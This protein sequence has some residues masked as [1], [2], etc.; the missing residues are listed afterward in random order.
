MKKLKTASRD[1]SKEELPAN[2]V[3]VFF[4]VIR[5]R[6]KTLL[7]VGMLLY[8]FFLPLLLLSSAEELISIQILGEFKE[9]IL[10]AGRMRDYMQVTYTIAGVLKAVVFGIFSVGI[11]GGVRILKRLIW[12]EGIQFSHDFTMGIRENGKKM[13]LLFFVVGIVVMMEKTAP[14]ILS[15][16]SGLSENGYTLVRS[17][18]TAVGTCFLLPIGAFVF[19]QIVFYENRLLA[20]IKNSIA[21]CGST[22]IRTYGI[23]MLMYLPYMGIL[24][25]CNITVKTL[26]NSVFCIVLLPLVFMIW[27]LY[28]C[29]VFDRF[30]NQKWYPDIVDK[31]IWRK[32]NKNQRQIP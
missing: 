21:F 24:H 18:L 23:L 29:A 1:L 10:D 25:F 7:G 17:L 14:Y 26:V 20:M 15:D 4:D 12:A 13:F 8:L 32:E 22:L 3:Q 6:W 11:S 27:L 9:G 28:S 31:G 5:N 2:R 30:V 19:S 16:A